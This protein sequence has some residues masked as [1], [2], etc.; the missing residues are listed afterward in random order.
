[1]S[2]KSDKQKAVLDQFIFMIDHTLASGISVLRFVKCSKADSL[3]SVFNELK[4]TF[5]NVIK[6][7]ELKKALTSLDDNTSYCIHLFNQA[8][9]ADTIQTDETFAPVISKADMEYKAKLAKALEAKQK[10][11]PG[12]DGQGGG[13]SRGSTKSD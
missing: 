9:L 6:K 1:M 7:E 8:L 2:S 13:A 4:T 5:Q 12:F 11:T 3:E 10:R